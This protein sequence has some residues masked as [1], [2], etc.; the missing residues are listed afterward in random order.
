MEEN[1]Y[2]QFTKDVLAVLKQIPYGKV[3]TYGD[4]AKAAGHPNGARQVVRILSSLSDKE[5]LPWHR[6]V[7]KAG[8]VV[9]RGD[10]ELEQITLLRSEGVEFISENI[11]DMK[12][13][14]L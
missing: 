6:V 2:T 14:K 3:T 5:N 4:V 10:G 11:V 8:Q 1:R 13:Y 12:N 9:L 7:N